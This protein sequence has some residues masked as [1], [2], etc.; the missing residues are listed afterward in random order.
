V[1]FELEV[2]QKAKRA[3]EA[4]VEESQQKALEVEEARRMAEGVYWRLPE[5]LP[6]PGSM[7]PNES[8]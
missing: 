5:T 3:V 8:Q 2:E 7:R 6:I 1:K 4:S